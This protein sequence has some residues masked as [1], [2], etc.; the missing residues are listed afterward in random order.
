MR[1]SYPT[2]EGLRRLSHEEDVCITEYVRRVL[3]THVHG[4]ETMATIAAEPYLR[5]GRKTPKQTAR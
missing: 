2:M 5:V 1:L 3:D 4:A